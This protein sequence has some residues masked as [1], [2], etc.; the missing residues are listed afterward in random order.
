MR[1]PEEPWL[2]A[3]GD[4]NGRTAHTHMG[5]YQSRIAADHI[6]GEDHAV[7][8]G[9]DGALSPR[10]VFTDIAAYSRVIG[11]SGGRGEGRAPRYRRMDQESTGEADGHGN[12][13]VLF[14]YDGTDQAKGCD[15]RSRPPAGTGPAGGG[16]GLWQPLA[17]LP[18]TAW[19]RPAS[20]RAHAHTEA[21]RSGAASSMR[22]PATAPASWCSGRAD[23]PASAGCCWA[24]SRPTWRTTRIARC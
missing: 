12:R 22:L 9:A 5:R 16:A 10:V 14:A 6:L 20:M 15:P 19:E 8:H 23:A 13:T 21:S 4:I 7:A 18:F 24:A 11:A 3:V 2:Y 1:V 17:A